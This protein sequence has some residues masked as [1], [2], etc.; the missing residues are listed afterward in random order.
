M[1]HTPSEKE[2]SFDANVLPSDDKEAAQVSAIDAGEVFKANIDGEDGVKMR[3]TSWPAAFALMFKVQF[4]LGILSIPAVMAPVGAVPGALLIIGWGAWNTW[5]AFIEGAFRNRH[6]GMHGIQDMMALVCGAW[7]REIV[8]NL[9][10]IGY[11]LVTGSGYI[12][13]AVAFNALSEHGAC[14]V[15][16]AFVTFVFCTACASF[17]RFSQIGVLC[18]VGV[19]S[20]YVAVFILVVA[21]GARSRPAMAPAGDFDLGWFPVGKD[22]SFLTGLSASTVIFISSSGHSANVPIIA[23]MRNPKEYKKPIALTMTILNVSYLVFGL[24]IYRYCGQYIA[25][26]SLGSAGTLIKKICYGIGLP[27]ILMS[28]TINQHLACKYLFVRVLRN[29]EHLQRKTKTHWVT[30]FGICIGVGVAGFVIAEAIPFFGTLLS[31]VSAISFTPLAIIVPAILWLFDFQRPYMRGS[32]AQKLFVLMHYLMILIGAFQV[33]G[34]AYS[35]IQSIIDQYA[36]G[37]VSSAF[38]CADNSNSS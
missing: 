38:T 2:A 33:V 12:A 36:A 13:G 14:T 18:W 32:V 5:A 15:W 37:T 23:E 10:F 3:T 4:S 31:F 28:T 11:V 9:F 20:L 30:W 7:G 8:G 26:P 27:G 16:F 34:G 29:S 1:S 25:S 35:A 19:V 21:V 22:I 6:P 24:V 17:P